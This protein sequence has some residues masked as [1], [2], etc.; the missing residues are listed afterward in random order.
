[1][2]DTLIVA[3]TI[4][5]AVVKKQMEMRGNELKARFPSFFMPR[6]KLDYAKRC[7]E[8]S[9]RSFDEVKRLSPEFGVM[10]IVPVG[11][12]GIFKALW[13]IGEAAD[14]GLSVDMKMIPIRQETVEICEWLGINPYT[15]DSADIPLISAEE[16]FSL[17]M[18]LLDAGIENVIIGEFTKKKGRTLRYL[19]HIRYIDKPRHF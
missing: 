3:G 4:A 8:E 17:H 11:R 16:G 15:A 19:E 9:K 14:S 13:D 5:A 7:L 18:T 10:H 12:G 1:M 2:G 6:M